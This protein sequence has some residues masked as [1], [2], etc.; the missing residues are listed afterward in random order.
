MKKLGLVFIVIGFLCYNT[1]A[2]A[3]LTVEDLEKIQQL[4][5]KFEERLDKRFTDLEKRF[6]TEIQSVEKNLSAE[7]QSVEKQF[8][9]EIKRL[10]QRITDQNKRLDYLGG[11][12]IALIVSIIGFVAV[13]MGFITYQYFKMRSQQDE[14]IKALREKVQ[15]LETQMLVENQD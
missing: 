2:F 11:L 13:P 9:I 15:A 1:S 3:A 12:M 6:T 5:D 14:E 7:I 4:L 10:D 8:S